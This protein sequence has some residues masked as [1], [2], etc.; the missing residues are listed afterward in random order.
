MPIMKNWNG[1]EIYDEVA[2]TKVEELENGKADTSHTHSADDIE[3]GIIPVENG[4]TGSDNAVDALHNLGI[5]WGT[6]DSEAY[7][8]E[9]ENGSEL[10]KNTIYIQINEE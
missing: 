7:W 3:D 4:G 9:I 8:S 5:Y 10:K 6:Q 2:R 1:Y